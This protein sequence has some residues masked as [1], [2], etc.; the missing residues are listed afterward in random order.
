VDASGGLED[1]P[2]AVRRGDVGHDGVEVALLGRQPVERGLRQGDAVVV[3][4]SGDDVGR[5]GGEAFAQAE[6]ADG[7]AG[8]GDPPDGELRLQDHELLLLGQRGP[9]R[10]EL[11]L[12]EDLHEVGRLG[13]RAGESSSNWM[14]RV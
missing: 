7:L 14:P 6:A 13:R 1:G 10:L 11:G 4:F 12:V 8:V 9:D 2:V 3:V 5:Q